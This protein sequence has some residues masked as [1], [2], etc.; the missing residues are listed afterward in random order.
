MSWG[1][2]MWLGKIPLRSQACPRGCTSICAHTS[3][4]P[5]TRP[6]LCAGKALLSSRSGLSWSPSSGS[7]KPLWMAMEGPLDLPRLLRITGRCF[8]T[9]AGRWGDEKPLLTAAAPS[10]CTNSRLT[11]AS[12]PEDR[13]HTFLIGVFQPKNK[14]A[15]CPICGWRCR[16]QEPSP[17]VLLATNEN[18]PLFFLSSTGG[19]CL[20][21]WLRPGFEANGQKL[22]G[23]ALSFS[24]S[25]GWDC[26]PLCYF[27]LTLSGRFSVKLC[28]S[29]CV[30]VCV[31]AG[32]NLRLPPE[33][34]QHHLKS[35]VITLI[36]NSLKSL[37]E[38]KAYSLHTNPTG[39]IFIW[40]RLVIQLW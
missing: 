17:S 12:S 11:F 31:C 9:S 34:C 8:Q 14:L 18:K 20:K 27:S 4:R 15:S 39:T 2:H 19:L 6:A 5:R 37:K 1:R 13:S 21:R 35:Q 24:G 23:W 3:V 29:N 10:I 7:D 32:G 36:S 40:L 28:Y 26:F 16:E 38:N 22:S 25:F 30:C 33:Q